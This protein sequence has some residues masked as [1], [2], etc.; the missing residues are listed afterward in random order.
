MTDQSA[1]AD[2]SNDIQYN[3]VQEPEKDFARNEHG[4]RFNVGAAGRALFQRI[5][6]RTP[7]G[8]LTTTRYDPEED[9][10]AD[11]RTASILPTS[12][13]LK[14]VTRPRCS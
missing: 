1:N 2:S 8:K 4:D 13:E 11:N 5:H 14:A 12:E 10:P 6:V 7:N 9:A 3:Y